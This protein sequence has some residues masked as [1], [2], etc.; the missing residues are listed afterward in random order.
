MKIHPSLGMSSLHHEI[1]IVLR[2]HV[3]LHCVSFQAQHF[4]F[5]TTNAFPMRTNRS[6][7]LLNISI[8][9]AHAS[10]SLVHD[11]LLPL[12]LLIDRCLL[13]TFHLALPILAFQFLDL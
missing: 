11:S 7:S 6:W 2:I 3:V 13:H 8:N 4:L 5:Y 10:S 12:P 9:Q 1:V